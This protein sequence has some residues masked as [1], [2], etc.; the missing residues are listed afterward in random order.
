MVFYRSELE[1]WV[2]QR[3]TSVTDQIDDLVLSLAESAN[4]KSREDRIC[5][6]Q[7]K[8]A[9]NMGGAKLNDN[10]TMNNICLYKDKIFH[11]H[12]KKGGYLICWPTANRVPLL[13][14]QKI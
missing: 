2:R 11:F 6:K 1:E 10:T 5:I 7:K 4:R 9:Q 13:I 12:D 8:T 3:T 14:Y